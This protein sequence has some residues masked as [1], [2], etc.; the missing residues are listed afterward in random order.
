MKNVEILAYLFK[1][2]SLAVAYIATFISL[3]IIEYLY[4]FSEFMY[5]EYSVLY[6]LLLIIL[7]F[8]FIKNSFEIMKQIG[9]I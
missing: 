6:H 1:C 9:D 5:F 7:Y 8:G 3:I 4:I 2:A